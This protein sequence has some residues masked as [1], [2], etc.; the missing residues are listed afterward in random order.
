[1]IPLIKPLYYL[2]NLSLSS[3]VFPNCWKKSFITQI[4]KL[5]D[6]NNILNYRPISK[7]SLIP[8][9]FEAL[10]TKKLVTLISNYI[11]PFQHGFRP[12]HS[13]LTNLLSYQTQILQSFE[14]CHQIDAIYTEFQKAFETCFTL[15][16]V[17]LLYKLNS[18]GFSGMFL[19][20]VSSYLSDLF[21][22]VKLSF[23]T[24]HEFSVTS[25]V[26]QGSHLGALLFLIFFDDL[27][28][29][30]NN[31][32]KILLY[33]DDAK[34]YCPI[35]SIADS[36]LLQM[37]LDLLFAWCNTNHL[38]LNI[39]KCHVISFTR[40]KN[41]IIFKYKISNNVLNRVHVIKDLGIHFE[42]DLSFKFNRKIVLNKSYKMLGFIN[43]NTQEFENVYCSLVRSSLEFGSLI[44]S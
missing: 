26:P 38:P 8:K 41:Q 39:T 36:E 19:L 12:K 21:Q 2:F 28:H 37:N 32:I 11:N 4:F 13:I 5:G 29:L 7:L 31:P 34:R 20:W 15:K 24:S 3:R 42:H 25:D 10:I 9:I 40:S 43:R 22:I 1:M 18:F 17:I 33:A 16:H 27:P 35:D 14:K 23:H 44:W 6:K 30:F